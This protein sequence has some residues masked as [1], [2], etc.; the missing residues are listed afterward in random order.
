MPAHS[1]EPL[2][3]RVKDAIEQAPALSRFEHDLSRQPLL[4]GLP[5]KIAAVFLRQA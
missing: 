5:Q 4:F 1:H 2:P 3:Q